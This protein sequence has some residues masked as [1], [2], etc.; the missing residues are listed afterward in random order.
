MSRRHLAVVFVGVRVKF[1]EGLRDYAQMLASDD[2]TAKT[3]RRKT[4]AGPALLLAALH[5][6]AGIGT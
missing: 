3:G 4:R 1:W 6:I 2:V 5:A